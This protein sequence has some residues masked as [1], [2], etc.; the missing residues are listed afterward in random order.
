MLQQ[1]VGRKALLSDLRC[2]GRLMPAPPFHQCSAEYRPLCQAN[3]VSK[4]QRPRCAEEPVRF[5]LR[6]Y[7]KV[8]VP[9]RQ[10]PLVFVWP[11]LQAGPVGKLI[12]QV[13]RTMLSRSKSAEQLSAV[14]NPPAASASMPPGGQL[15]PLLLDSGH[16]C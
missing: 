8:A 4:G 12:G 14:R 6:G 10:V 2:M 13:I 9:P 3:I 1:K 7:C 11:P 16:N 15:A 5:K